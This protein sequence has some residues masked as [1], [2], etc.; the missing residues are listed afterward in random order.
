MHLSSIFKEYGIDIEKTKIIRHPLNKED[1]RAAYVR[2]MIE[3]Y[4][5]S[6][7]KNC[8]YNC[9]YIA[10]FIGTNKTEALFI[11][12]YEIVDSITGPAVKEKMPEE[13]PNPEHFD[14]N[15]MYYVM[16]KLDAMSDLI[17]K[18]VIEWGK[19]TLSWHH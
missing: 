6:Q 16:K 7:S 19:S 17:D 11:G 13:Y 9:K 1:V 8:F 10:S 14:G 12:L 2:G 5:S 3:D 18:L 4:Q 15:H